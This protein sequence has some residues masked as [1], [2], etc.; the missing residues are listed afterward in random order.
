MIESCHQ[1]PPPTHPF[2]CCKIS[3]PSF[4]VSIIFY[5]LEVLILQLC[6]NKCSKFGLLGILSPWLRPGM[7]LAQVHECRSDRKWLTLLH[8]G[9]LCRGGPLLSGWRA[10]PKS[11]R[12]RDQSP[13][14]NTGAAA[15]ACYF[16]VCSNLQKLFKSF[17]YPVYVTLSMNFFIMVLL[18]LMRFL[19]KV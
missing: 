15:N 3:N 2:N 18:M 4:F 6:Q 11:K 5:M 10:H 1:K 13:G 8:S 17:S 16:Q 19:E 7:S 12:A 14:C 9:G